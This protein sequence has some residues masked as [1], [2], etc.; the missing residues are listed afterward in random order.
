MTI[1]PLTGA[2]DERTETLYISEE[3]NVF[4]WTGQKMSGSDKEGVLS[5]KREKDSL[6][7]NH[8][9]RA[10]VGV[11]PF[12][13]LSEEKLKEMK[14]NARDIGDGKKSSLRIHKCANQLCVTDT[15]TKTTS[16]VCASELDKEIQSEH[17]SLS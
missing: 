2:L 3:F 16:R 4:L 17:F 7:V 9:R 11:V 5:L 14:E 6:T 10:F 15:A 13:N 8:W 12:H 1:N